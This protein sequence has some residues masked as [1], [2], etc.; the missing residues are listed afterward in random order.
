M[1]KHR[2]TT[3]EILYSPQ[4]VFI[5]YSTPDFFRDACPS[6]YLNKSRDRFENYFLATEVTMYT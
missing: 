1:R 4:E 5:P 3:R 2:Q 6:F